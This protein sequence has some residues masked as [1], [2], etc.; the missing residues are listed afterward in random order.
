MLSYDY[1]VV[2]KD[3][4]Q[5]SQMDEVPRARSW[6]GGAHRASTPSPG[7]LPSQHLSVFTTLETPQTSLF[8][9]VFE[10]SLHRHD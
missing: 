7:V 4:T 2:I 1:S 10:A 5:K 8:R 3:T 9:S 6:G